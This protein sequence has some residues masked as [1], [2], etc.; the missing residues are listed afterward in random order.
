[1]TSESVDRA[2]SGSPREQGRA[3]TSKSPVTRP[4]R[5]G[6]SIEARRT[7]DGSTRFYARFTDAQG[8][9]HVAPPPDGDKT[10]DDWGQAFAAA[11]ARQDE[12]QRLSYRSRDGEKL[13]FRDLAAHHYLPRIGRRSVHP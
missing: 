3:K 11:C 10:W 5:A 12:A 1:M 8:R 9:R 2:F 13:L 4:T 7:S 6:V